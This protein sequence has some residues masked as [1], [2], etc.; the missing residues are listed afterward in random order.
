MKGESGEVEVKTSMALAL[1][2][3]E[4]QFGIYAAVDC[5]CLCDPGYRFSGIHI[6]FTAPNITLQ[7]H[8]HQFMHT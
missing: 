5:R 7:V 6:I 3:S 4:C 1:R 8:A 2:P